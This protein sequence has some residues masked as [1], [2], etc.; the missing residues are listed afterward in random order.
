MS[1]ERA[2]ALGDKAFKCAFEGCGRLYTTQHHLKVIARKLGKVKK[3]ASFREV[4]L[5]D[6]KI[7]SGFY[8]DRY[9]QDHTQVTGHL[10]VNL[11]AVERHLLQGMVLNLTLEYTLVR[12]HTSVQKKHVA[13][14]LRLLAIFRNMSEHIQVCIMFRLHHAHMNAEA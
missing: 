5:F 7:L 1:S 11:P 8:N 13:R 12:N 9:M 2:M 6:I 3:C 14:R 10:D 4:S